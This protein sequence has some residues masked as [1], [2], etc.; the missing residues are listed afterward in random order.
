M[1]AT[2]AVISPA[3]RP[4]D[5]KLVTSRTAAETARPTAARPPM[6]ITL[7]ART[8]RSFWPWRNTSR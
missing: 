2:N 1:A 5:T 8:S 6:A 3:A 4:P 7:A